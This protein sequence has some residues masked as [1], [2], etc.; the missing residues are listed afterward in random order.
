MSFTGI[1]IGNLGKDAEVRQAGSSTVCGFSVAA[2]VGFGD[3]AKTIWIDCSI[4]GKRA[5]SQL[6][7]YLKKGTKVTVIGEMNEREY[8]GKT[9]LTCDV[10]TI[11]LGSNASDNG[12]QQNNQSYQ[13][14]SN[15]QQAPSNYAQP[16]APNPYAQQMAQNAQ[17]MQDTINQQF[18]RQN[19]APQQFNNQMSQA[20]QNGAPQVPEDP[21]PF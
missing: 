19:Q 4:W 17:G 7:Q 20:P 15:N 6:P 2:K 21:I 1:V 11:D 18:A 3:K 9:Y 5:E 8:N 12:G 13:Q 14:P 16:Q 10:H